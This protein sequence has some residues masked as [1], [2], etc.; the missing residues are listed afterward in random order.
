MP[1]Y[2]WAL[3]AMD[4]GKGTASAYRRRALVLRGVKNKKAQ[5]PVLKALERQRE[6]EREREKE[7][8]RDVY[9]YLYKRMVFCIDRSAPAISKS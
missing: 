8:E 7:R 4:K 1:V 5:E 9:L 2:A 6:R 3:L